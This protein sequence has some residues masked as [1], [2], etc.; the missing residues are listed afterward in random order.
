[1]FS[2]LSPRKSRSI[3]RLP[4]SHS[5]S[6]G[7]RRPCCGCGRL[8]EGARGKLKICTHIKDMLSSVK[9]CKRRR[10]G[11]PLRPGGEMGLQ[12]S[13]H[14][15]T[16]AVFG[17]CTTGHIGLN[18]EAALGFVRHDRTLPFSRHRRLAKPCVRLRTTGTFLESRIAG[19]RHLHATRSSSLVAGPPSLLLARWGA[20]Q[21][22]APQVP[23]A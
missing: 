2:A 8:G 7:G 9:A 17:E 1:M 5:R 14:C 21:R 16:R 6:K 15:L 13:Q 12:S 18:A 19:W 23:R 4:P 10:P 20:I 11:P 3:A 22:P